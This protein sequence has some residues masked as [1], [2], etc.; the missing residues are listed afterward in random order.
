VPAGFANRPHCASARAGCL[1][2]Q[3]NGRSPAGV[4]RAD[5]ASALKAQSV[6]R[7][8]YNHSKFSLRC[9]RVIRKLLVAPNSFGVSFR[10]E[11]KM[12]KKP[13]AKPKEAPKPQ[14]KSSEKSGAKKGGKK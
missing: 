3:Y 7:F 10:G 5:P 12:A 14:E 8:H 4:A 11:T 2:E 1:A 9:D 13:E 6:H